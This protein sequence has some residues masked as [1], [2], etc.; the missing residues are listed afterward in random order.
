MNQICKQCEQ[1]FEVSEQDL[2]FYDKISPVFSGQ[3]YAVPAPTLCPLCRR[4]RRFSFRNESSL[5]YR[6]CDKSGELILS[7]YRAD[8]PFPVYSPAVWF[9]DSWDA[10]SYGR[11]FDFNRPFFEQ[12]LELRNA[13]PHLSL[14]SSNNENCDYCNIVGSSKNCYLCFG[15]V[16]SENC[17]YG[18]PFRCK[19]CCDSLLLRNSELCLNCIDSNRLYNCYSCFNCNDSQDLFLCSEVRNSHHCF[20]CVGLNRKEYFIFNKPY[21]KEDYFEFLKQT[22]LRDETTFAKIQQEIQALKMQVPHRFY[23]GTNNENVSGN[24][25]FDSKNCLESFNV[26]QGQDLKNV[27]QMMASKDCMD[28]SNGEYGELNYEMMAYYNSASLLLFSY[29]CWDGVYDLMYSAN[30]AQNVQHCFGCMGL[31]HAS[32]CILNKQYSKEEYEALV[33]RIIEHIKKTGEWGE[34]FPVNLSPFAY[35]ETMAY[36][37]F[38]LNQEQVAALGGSWHN[39]ASIPQVKANEVLRSCEVTGKT[40]KMIPQ[41]LSFYERFKAP[42]PKRAPKQRHLDRLAQR[43]PM[44]LFERHC[45]SCQKSL[46]SSYAPERPEKIYCEKCYLEVVY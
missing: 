39:D 6:N 3:K 22:D 24:Y 46:Q 42:L 45:F 31:K 41:E 35:N 15:M 25:I 14:I 38:P 36:E 8:A 34:F 5:Y 29:F 40:F 13:V 23:F 1:N 17:Y 9:G 11:E 37:H 27:Y 18:N 4:Q 20:G 26:E 32:Y 19:D 21:S 12:F 10:K 28:V 16:E 2:Q 44:I 7:M 30:C 33:P 43:N